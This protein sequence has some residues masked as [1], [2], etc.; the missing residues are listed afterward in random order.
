MTTSQLENAGLNSNPL[1][2]TL[3]CNAPEPKVSSIVNENVREQSSYSVI[4]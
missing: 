4:S 2:K 3:C 1:E